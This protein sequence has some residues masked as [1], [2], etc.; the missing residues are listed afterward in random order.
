MYIELVFPMAGMCKQHKYVAG[1]YFILLNCVGMHS[2]YDLELCWRTY[3]GI[4]W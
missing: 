1:D 4:L 3:D 2:T